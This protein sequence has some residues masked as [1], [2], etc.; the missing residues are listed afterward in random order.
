MYPTRHEKNEW[1]RLANAAYRNGM[2]A[3]GHTFSAAAALPEG[4]EISTRQFDFYQ[5]VYREWL[6]FGFAGLPQIYNALRA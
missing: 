4:A 1:A 2:N 3:I 6:V 5:R